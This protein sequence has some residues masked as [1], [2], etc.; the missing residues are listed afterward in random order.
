M[1]KP[2]SRRRR[3]DPGV[4]EPERQA[5]EECSGGPGDEHAE[6]L[7]GGERQGAGIRRG[8]DVQTRGHPRSP[9]PAAV[10]R[11]T[12]SSQPVPPTVRSFAHS[13]Q[14]PCEPVVPPGAQFRPARAE[15]YHDAALSAALN[16]TASGVSSR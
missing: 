16:S 2:V 14:Q 6:A 1:L 7:S 13:A 11:T 15:S 12:S 8:L 3:T 4:A 5:A 9:A 10:V